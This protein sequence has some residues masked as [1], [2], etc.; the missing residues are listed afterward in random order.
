[1]D[2][3]PI[4]GICVIG[5]SIFSLARL[6]VKKKTIP[7]HPHVQNTQLTESSCNGIGTGLRQMRKAFIENQAEIA[8]TDK[9]EVGG[10]TTG[11]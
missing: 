1:M 7:L 11:S 5:G 10:A 6:G 8:A 9:L 4:R 3:M 2:A